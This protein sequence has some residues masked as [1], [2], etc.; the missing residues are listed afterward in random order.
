MKAN[1]II[2]DKK[3]R[4]SFSK[5]EIKSLIFK[6]LIF[7]V[8]CK[9]SKFVFQ[10]LASSLGEQSSSARIHNRCF[11]TGRGHS[12]DSFVGISRLMFREKTNL[13]QLVGIKKKSW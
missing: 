9:K 12:V 10:Q 6:A 8:G 5:T 4:V 7:S 3:K 13:G 11:L 2:S 1:Y